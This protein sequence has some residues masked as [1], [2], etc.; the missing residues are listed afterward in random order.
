MKGR[1]RSDSNR[2]RRRP[3]ADGEIDFLAW[4]SLINCMRRIDRMEWMSH[5]AMKKQS[6][7]QAVGFSVNVLLISSVLL[8][9][10]RLGLGMFH[11]LVPF[12]ILECGTSLFFFSREK[13]GGNS[14]LDAA[15]PCP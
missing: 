14:C 8:D 1:Q 13:S 3:L 11:A 5:R 6:I 7:F 12:W 4:S 15:R 2:S 9:F 10:I